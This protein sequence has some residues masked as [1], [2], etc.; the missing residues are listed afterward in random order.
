MPPF[1]IATDPESKICEKTGSFVIFEVAGV[2]VVSTR[3]ISYVQT[4]NFGFIDCSR[5]RNTSRILK[6]WTFSDSDPKILEQERSLKMWLRPPL[7]STPFC[8]STTKNCWGLG[9]QVSFTVMQQWLLVE[10]HKLSIAAFAKKHSPN[11]S[12]RTQA[13]FRKANEVAPNLSP[14]I[15]SWVDVCLSWLL[16]DGSTQKRA[17]EYKC[18]AGQQ[19]R[20]AFTETKCQSYAGKQHFACHPLSVGKHCSVSTGSFPDH[21][22]R[23]SQ[24]RPCPSEI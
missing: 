2:Y 24:G 13:S 14:F 17:K 3:V 6:F 15:R 4:L 9:K 10:V 23:R 21:Q 20:F 1:R 18:F 16:Q 12:K 5:S 8:G 19:R 11:S 22:H 7:V